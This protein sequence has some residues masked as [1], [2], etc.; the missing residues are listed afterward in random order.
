MTEPSAVRLPPRFLGDLSRR[1]TRA[2][3]DAVGAL[4]EA[5]RELGGRLIDDLPGDRAPD[6]AP[7]DVFWDAAAGLLSD[8]GLGRLEVE[9]R[10][11]SVAELRL[12]DSPEAADPDAG[13]A[14]EAPRRGC[15]LA[16]GLLAG[17]LTSTAD[18]PVAVLEVTCAGDG[19]GVCR[20]LAGSPDALSGI[21]RRLEEGA[22]VG[23]ALEAP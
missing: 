14:G 20:W 7:P 18:E 2:G 12:D 4:R 10:T 6:R 16:T 11:P 15:P 1:C 5:G 21:R 3:A 8:R 17:L 23:E 22:S 13:S 19:D 9:I